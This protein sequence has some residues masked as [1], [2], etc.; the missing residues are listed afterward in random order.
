MNSQVLEPII[1]EVLE[2][3]ASTLKEHEIEFYLIGAAAR[4]IVLSKDKYYRAKRATRDVD[5]AILV[6]SETEFNDL[7]ELLTD[8]GDFAIVKNNAI[9]LVYKKAIEVDLLPFGEIENE[10]R[11][12]RIKH[13]ELLINVPGLKE[14]LPFATEIDING[15]KLNVCPLEG[16]IILKLFS[17]S[18]NPARTKDLTDIEQ[19][20]DAYFDLN[21]DE[22]Y[23]L[24]YDVLNEYATYQ[25]DSFELSV[26]QRLVGR[27]IKA[28]LIQ[29]PALIEKLKEILQSQSPPS[30]YWQE[31]YEGL[32]DE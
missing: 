15:T 31:I 8:T 19:L 6:A 25:D 23:S 9:R 18:E 27:K 16:I 10:G 26:S 21:T 32:A 2:A 13:P 3:V 30:T 12:V 11:E 28:L 14:L 7:K 22:I 29:H 4:D 20:L 1:E 17:Y 24:Y 5:F